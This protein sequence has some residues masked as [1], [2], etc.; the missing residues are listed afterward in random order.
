MHYILISDKVVKVMNKSIIFKSNKPKQNIYCHKTP[1][2]FISL[3]ETCI[4]IDLGREFVLSLDQTLLF[5]IPV[6]GMSCF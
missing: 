6:N 4:N 1:I 3:A 2:P 5:Q